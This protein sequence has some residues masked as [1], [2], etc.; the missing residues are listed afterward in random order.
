MELL[1]KVLE[2]LGSPVGVAAVAFVWDA[3]RRL[4]P[5]KNP[6]GLLTDVAALLSK[7]LKY[8]QMGVDVL[9]KVGQVVA[10][11]GPNKLAEPK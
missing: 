5:T 8:A 7:G 2:F 9:G 3:A 1:D 4:F 11:I 10:K 6:A